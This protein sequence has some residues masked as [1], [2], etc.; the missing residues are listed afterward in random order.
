MSIAKILKSRPGAH[1]P[2]KTAVSDYLVKAA[3]AQLGRQDV[4]LAKAALER[5]NADAGRQ[6]QR[7]IYF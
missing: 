2:A 4:A 3:A 1:A 7:L 6:T 5:I